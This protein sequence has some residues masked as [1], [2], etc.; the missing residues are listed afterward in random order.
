MNEKQVIERIGKKR[1]ME[2]REFMKGQTVQVNSDNS[3]HYYEWD[4][5]N[6]LRKNKDRF[7]D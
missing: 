5:E 4:V 1:R 3:I 7:F 6:F 2:F